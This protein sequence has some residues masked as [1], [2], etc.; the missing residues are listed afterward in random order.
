MDVSEA[1]F[2]SITMSSP[3]FEAVF[4]ALVA[5]VRCFPNRW[6]EE[7]QIVTLICAELVKPKGIIEFLDYAENLVR[8]ARVV[9]R[10]PL[11]R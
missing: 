3:H 10:L 5:A 4:E 1:Q 6:S 9:R 2:A 7:A 11:S 8:A